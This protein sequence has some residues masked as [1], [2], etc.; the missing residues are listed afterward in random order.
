MAARVVAPSIGWGA[1]QTR[2]PVSNIW[3]VGRNYA[4]HA[5]ELGNAVPTSPVVFLKATSSIR[6][7]HDAGVLAHAGE[8]FHHEAELVLLIGEH[9]PHGSA[10][11]PERLVACVHGVGLGLD[12]TRRGVQASLKEKGLPWLMAK[13]FSGAAVVSD[14]VSDF[15]LGAIEYSLSVNREARQYARTSDMVFDVPAILAHLNESHDLLPGDLV[16]T[17]TPEGVGP[18]RAGDVFELAFERGASGRFTGKL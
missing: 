8:E 16:F 1:R 14:F 9:V 6:G 12:L 3:C 18:M 5:A 7:V 11:A 10:A 13:S 2:T 17:G 15:D 4:K